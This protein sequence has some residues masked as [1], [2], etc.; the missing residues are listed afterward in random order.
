MLVKF[1]SRENVAGKY[2]QAGAVVTLSDK[3][4][5]TSQFKQLVRSGA[6]SVQPRDEAAQKMQGHRDASS[7]KKAQSAAPSDLQTRIKA[8]KDVAVKRAA[9][10]VALAQAG[11]QLSAQY[12]KEVSDQH[13]KIAAGL[14]ES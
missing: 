11:D 5:Y 2:Y 6:V 3:L 13:N 12:H 4:F 8:H 9:K 14:E 7:H 10:S 1:N